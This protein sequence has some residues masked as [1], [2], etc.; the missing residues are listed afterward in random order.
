MSFLRT[1]V[2]LA[3]SQIRDD[4]SWKYICTN[5]FVSYNPTYGGLFIYWNNF[6]VYEFMLEK[7]FF[8]T[9][10][11]QREKLFSM[12]FYFLCVEKV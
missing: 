11:F 9:F 5:C 6:I 1:Y 7:N 10:K 12:V 8:P 3:M 4:T 2:R